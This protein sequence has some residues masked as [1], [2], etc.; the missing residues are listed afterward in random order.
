MWLFT[1]EKWLKQVHIFIYKEIYNV[2]QGEKSYPV[3]R[4]SLLVWLR[5]PVI[6]KNISGWQMDS[7]YSLSKPYA[8]PSPLPLPFCSV[9]L[10]SQTRKAHELSASILLK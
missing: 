10:V 5:N 7:Y 4:Y 8:L 6:P 2:L 3:I 1:W 9:G